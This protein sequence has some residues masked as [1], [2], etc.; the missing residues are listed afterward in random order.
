M[1][2]NVEVGELTAQLPLFE[3][4]NLSEMV[5]VAEVHESDVASIAIDDLA[6]IRS[7]ALG[8]TLKGRVLR[9]DRVVG[10]TQMRSPNPMARSDFR[11]I[12]VWIE[13]DSTDA[14]EAAQ[15][16][17]LQVDVSINKTR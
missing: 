2:A 10:A 16:L 5:C 7:S 1:T 17:Q 4:A 8:R 9:I 13:I 6:E 14:A 15:R 11:S 12:P 3:L